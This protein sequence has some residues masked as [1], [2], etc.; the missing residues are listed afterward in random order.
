M[1]PI[2]TLISPQIFISRQG[3]Y[4]FFPR[5]LWNRTAST[6]GI[7]WLF[8]ICCYMALLIALLICFRVYRWFHLSKEN[9]LF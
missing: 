3:L 4:I 5:A 6:C 7:N 9:T 2:D 1:T 8:A